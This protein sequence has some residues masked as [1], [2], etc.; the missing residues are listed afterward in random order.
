MEGLFSEDLEIELI[1]C[2]PQLEEMEALK[3]MKK[4]FAHK[5]SKEL[6][7]VDWYAF[8]EFVNITSGEF[9]EKAYIHF[10]NGEEWNSHFFGF[11]SI[12]MD[13]RSREITICLWIGKEPGKSRFQTIKCR[14]ER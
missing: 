12:L 9:G 3:K 6:E 5:L 7:E 14:N 2:K 11:L 10:S 4:E 8:V 13:I 1:I